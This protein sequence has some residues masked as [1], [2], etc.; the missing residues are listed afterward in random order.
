MPVGKG[1]D[2]LHPRSNCGPGG[3][4]PVDQL[5]GEKND[6]RQTN[7]TERDR[8]S[9][10]GVGQGQDLQRLSRGFV[11]T[12]DLLALLQTKIPFVSGPTCINNS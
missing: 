3:L 9:E 4:S 7:R 12:G 6:E 5:D 1:A 11:T 10:N 2:G 8:E